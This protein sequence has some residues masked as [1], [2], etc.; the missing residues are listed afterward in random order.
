M[1]ILLLSSGSR[2]KLVEYFV[3]EFNSYGYKVYTA[4]CS[5]LAPT[6]YVSNGYFIVPRITEEN[7]LESIIEICKENN[8]GAVLS[9]ID[10]E[11]SLLAENIELFKSNGIIPIISG[12]EEVELCFDKHRMYQF[13]K[14]NSIDTPKTF[15]NLATLKEELRKNQIEFPL[16]A[17]PK[18]GSASLNMQKINNLKDLKSFNF[19]KDYIVQE[20]IDGKE[21]GVDVYVDLY[22]G[23]VVDM[24]IKEKIVMRAGETDKS[25]SI[26]SEEIRE[27]IN[28][29]LSKI[30]LK[31][32][33]DIDLFE[34]SGKLMLSEVNPRFGGG[35]LHA[36]ESKRNFPKMILN[37][38]KREVN[39][40][41]KFEFVETFAMKFSDLLVIKSEG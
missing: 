16:F 9:L 4:D 36:H 23:E 28:D 29:L 13:L 30:K 17:K 35:Y 37:N 38:L 27:F 14:D 32:P 24:F 5:E 12:S 21:Y 11:L 7:Y 1:N 20:F 19:D 39:D 34:K 26:D 15:N 25:V 33:I 40:T 10:P 2:V 3:K 41:Q 22:S 18:N 31:G 8:I 6:L